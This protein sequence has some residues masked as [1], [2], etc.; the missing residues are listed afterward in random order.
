MRLDLTEGG[1]ALERPLARSTADALAAS[2][3]V[4]VTPSTT[5]GWWLVAPGTKV[6][7]A[8]VAGV[9]VWIAPKLEI[10]RLFF[11]LGYA[12]D[13]KGWREDDVLLAEQPDP[14]TAVATAFARQADRA[15]QQG[16]LQGYRVTEESLAVVRGRIRTDEQLRRRFGLSIPVEVRYDDFSVDIVENQLLRAAAQRLLRLPGVSPSTRRT[17]LRLLRSTA[18]ASPLHAGA[19]LPPWQ[20]SRL[21]ARYHVALRLAEIVLRGTSLEQL[22]GM[23]H[24]NGFLLD[25]ARV[26]EDFLTV[27][28]TAAL[29]AYGGRIRPQYTCHLDEA[30]RIQLRPDLVWFR[31]AVDDAPGAVADAKYKAE[32]PDGF[33]NADLYQMLTYCTVLGLERG[34]LVY[35]KGNEA[36]AEHLVRRAGI[37]ITQ[38]ALDLN[39]DPDAVLAQVAAIAAHLARAQP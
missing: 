5:P 35:A 7:V 30:D 36:A 6:G 37:T 18:D 17:L 15:L 26:F 33:P 2:G 12:R 38:H 9:E 31:S 27:T 13:G 34:H 22:T 21:N 20:R 3:V 14:L 28:L 19:P 25:M 10:R 16:L 29:E 11:L 24:V 23:V 32:K 39:A 8:Q 1:P 4:T